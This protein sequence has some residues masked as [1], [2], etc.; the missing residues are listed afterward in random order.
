MSSKQIL[1]VL[2][3]HRS[4]TSLIAKSLE[5]IGGSLGD[6]LLPPGDDNPKGFWED[7]EFNDLNIEILSLL[8][9]KWYSLSPVELQTLEKEQ[10]DYLFAKAITLTKSKLQ[11]NPVWILKDPRASLLMPFWSEVF[12][13]LGVKPNFVFALRHPDS[14]CQSLWKRNHFNHV[15]SAFIWFKH[16]LEVIKF[17]SSEKK[18]NYVIVDYDQFLAAPDPSIKQFSESFDLPIIQEKLKFLKNDFIDISLRHTVSDQTE[19]ENDERLDFIY[20]LYETL[21]TLST[22]ESTESLK[23]S[24]T[25]YQEIYSALCISFI[26]LDEYVEKFFAAEQNSFKIRDIA[27]YKSNELNQLKEEQIAI[28]QNA[29]QDRI[30]FQVEREYN[31]SLNLQIEK[32]KATMTILEQ[33]LTNS[34]QQRDKLSEQLVQANHGIF[35]VT[36]NI[37]RLSQENV[38]V[39][40][41][42]KLLSDDLQKF[43][44]ALK[45]QNESN[46]KLKHEQQLAI[47]QVEHLENDKNVLDDALKKA[48]QQIIAKDSQL[49]EIHERTAKAQESHDLYAD[50]L[51]HNKNL[52]SVVRDLRED[53]ERLNTQVGNLQEDNEQLNALSN[54][55]QEDNKR[56]NALVEG[57]QEQQQNSD[58]QLSALREKLNDYQ[59]ELDITQQKCRD[60]TKQKADLSRENEDLSADLKQL[61]DK[62]HQK[63][64]QLITKDQIIQD[65]DQLITAVKSS[66]VGRLFRLLR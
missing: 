58:T 47:A 41:A 39:N 50:Q 12:N 62:M 60:L 29:S 44:Q 53:N 7:K 21:K 36:K 23:A 37:T 31:A 13:K 8:G 52:E 33:S 30:N 32:L 56:I 11:K 48:H 43:I 20:G 66:K 49:T 27:D 63:N 26:A 54:G 55:L 18:S 24:C 38:K 45:E 46:D 59:K 5:V 57:L 15:F 25:H 64:L 6:N 51:K 17:L 16:N 65:K 40:Q 14:V 22:Q 42:N 4:G 35:E 9:Q 28:K 3:M 19:D 61:D 1:M 10:F 2:G 34:E